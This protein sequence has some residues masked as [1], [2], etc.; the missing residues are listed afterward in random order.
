MR[1]DQKEIGCGGGAWLEHEGMSAEESMAE[2]EAAGEV[3]SGVEVERRRR[4][5]KRGGE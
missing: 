3:V 2:H 1:R 4:R 5:S